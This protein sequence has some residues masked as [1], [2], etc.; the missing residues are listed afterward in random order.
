MPNQSKPQPNW[1]PISALP[2]IAYAIDGMYAGVEQ[3]YPTLL[4]A[5]QRPYVLDNATVNRVVNVYTQQQQDLWLFEE[6]L[7][8]W[9]AQPLTPSQQ[10]EVTRL[11]GQLEK[12]RQHLAAIL[13]VAE[14]LK[15]GTIETVLEKDDLELGI[16]FL[17]GK[18]S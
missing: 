14:E 13:S 7:K 16:D 11:E 5:K 8:R 9:Q 10:Q 4:E 3:Q 1:Q 12:L 2:T 17:S 15:Q 6:Q 18:L